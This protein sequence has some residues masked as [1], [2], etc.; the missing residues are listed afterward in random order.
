V[1]LEEVTEIMVMVA[2]AL[3]EAAVEW[4]WQDSQVNR[5]SSEAKSRKMG[6]NILDHGYQ[7]ALFIE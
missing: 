4:E 7:L 5:M 2:L 3:E 6:F 1:V